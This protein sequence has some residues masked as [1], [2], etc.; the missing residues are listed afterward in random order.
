MMLRV[1]RGGG[2]GMEEKSLDVLGSSG[3]SGLVKWVYIF[4]RCQSLI[5]RIHYQVLMMESRD[6]FLYNRVHDTSL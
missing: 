2:G 3:K 5:T 4:I 6:I 1:R